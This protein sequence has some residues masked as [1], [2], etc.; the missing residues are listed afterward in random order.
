M[1]GVTIVKRNI[2]FPLGGNEYD[3]CIKNKKKWGRIDLTHLI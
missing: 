3:D 2:I 1:G